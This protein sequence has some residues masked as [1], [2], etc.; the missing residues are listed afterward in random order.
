MCMGR[1]SFGLVSYRV[2]AYKVYRTWMAVVTI[3]CIGCQERFGAYSLSEALLCIGVI[4]RVW[5]LHGVEDLGRVGCIGIAVQ[6]L[7]G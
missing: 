1:M 4:S 6:C 7:Q 5:E 3:G 2:V